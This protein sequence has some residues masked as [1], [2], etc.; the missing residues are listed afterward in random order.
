MVVLKNVTGK[1]R[2]FWVLEGI[3]LSTLLA[4]FAIKVTENAKQV[5]K[6]DVK[7]SQI[8]NLYGWFFILSSYP[9]TI[10]VCALMLSNAASMPK[11]SLAG[12]LLWP[13]CLPGWFSFR[14]LVYCWLIVGG[15]KQGY[16][17]LDTFLVYDLPLYS[18][19]LAL[20][21][22]C[23][24]GIC[25]KRWE[26]MTHLIA[27]WNRFN[28][29]V[30]RRPRKYLLRG[31]LAILVTRLGIH[32]LV[33]SIFSEEYVLKEVLDV[34]G[35][36]VSVALEGWLILGML[37]AGKRA[38]PGHVPEPPLKLML[39]G[40]CLSEGSTACSGFVNLLEPLSGLFEI[41]GLIWTLILGTLL[42]GEE[43]GTY[44]VAFWA[45]ATRVRTTVSISVSTWIFA[46]T[47]GTVK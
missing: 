44:G 39:L 24:Y 28:R 37:A 5:S 42:W 40:W 15:L 17:Y 9:V 27:D 30:D 8:D 2:L 20:C 7:Y 18:V 32:A 14:V 21:A 47:F 13:A 25:F 16:L 1:W 6:Y 41:A 43:P 19:L 45:V 11:S 34:L 46:W 23:C 31:G 38:A 35:A 12:R 29:T 36:L 10:T 26:L 33:M 4:V 22:C 3:G